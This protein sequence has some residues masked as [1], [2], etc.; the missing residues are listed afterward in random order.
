MSRTSAA[1]GSTG[2]TVEV[3]YFAAARAA[4][5]HVKAENVPLPFDELTREQFAAL[6]VS[7]HPQPPAGEPDL[8][9]V[10]AQSTLLADGTALVAEDDL[11]RGGMRVDVLPPFAGG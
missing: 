5:G 7:L 11:V 1:G 6:L 10:L 2:A 8:E 4:A 9:R 3:R